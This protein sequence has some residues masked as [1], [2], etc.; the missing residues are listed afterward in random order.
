MKIGLMTYF[1]VDNTGQF[2]QAL[3][4]IQALR[5]AYPDSEIEL[6]NIRHERRP[7]WLPP[8][9]VPN[10]L[11]F[12]IRHLRYGHARAKSLAPY[13][14]ST[15]F[16]RPSGSEVADYINRSG[17]DVIITGADTC[18]KVDKHWGDNLPPYWI[19]GEV[20]AKKFLMSATAENTVISDLSPKQLAAAKTSLAGISGINVRDTMTQRLAAELLPERESDIKIV[21]DPTFIL[22]LDTKP[23]SKVQS[24]AKKG[25]PLCGVNLPKTPV[26]VAIIKELTKKY[27]VFSLNRPSNQGE[28]S[29]FLGPWQWLGMWKSIDAM[30]TSSFHE[31]IF[32]MRSGV[33]V[34][35]MDVQVDRAGRA[36]VRSKAGDLLNEASLNELFWNL[37]AVTEAADII[38]ALEHSKTIIRSSSV[39]G[40]CRS[41]GESYLNAI[42][43]IAG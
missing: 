3:A 24:L 18:L 6:L 28:P 42:R 9:S 19:P 33:P 41:Q 20:R 31:T 16:K 2:F 8:K 15:A 12:L 43:S 39:V 30:V 40:H 7:T 11:P 22:D 29:L 13:T 37:P 36:G 23:F 35:S 27:T 1:S 21:G 26:T 10:V 5:T 25:K 4:T 17:F 14:G 34:I 38:N 32:S